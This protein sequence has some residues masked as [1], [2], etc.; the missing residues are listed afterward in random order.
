MM[1][2][3][4]LIVD[5]SGMMRR[6][7]QARILST[8]DDAVISEA[9]SIAQ[10]A[11]VMDTSTVHLILYSWDIQDEMGLQFCKE[12]AAGRN[13]GVVPFLF[14]I[15]DKKEH[16]AMAYELVGNAYLVMPCSAEELARA[17][18]RVCSPVRLR[19]AKRYSIG[20]TRAV[21]E[22]RQVQVEAQ[23]MNLSAGGSLCEFDLDPHLN[24]AFPMIMSI[25][26]GGDEG[27]ETVKELSVVATNMLVITRQNDQTPKRI[28][29]GFKFVHLPDFAREIFTRAFAQ[30]EDE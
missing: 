16:V 10:A 18:D 8:I 20:D 27:Q 3:H 7:L 14:L 15:N 19:Q 25:Q 2:R 12:S 5:E 13:G 23:V 21:I 28:R 22:Q 9:S 26:F 1:A 17:I 6:V 4:I 11:H 24:C 29:M 30:A